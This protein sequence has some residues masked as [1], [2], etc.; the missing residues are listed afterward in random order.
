MVGLKQVMGKTLF[1]VEL[2]WIGIHLPPYITFE[3]GYMTK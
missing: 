1:W 3:A 2:I